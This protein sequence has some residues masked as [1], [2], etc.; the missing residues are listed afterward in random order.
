MFV[1]KLYLLHHFN[2][3]HL[4]KMVNVLVQNRRVR[5]GEMPHRL[6][7]YFFRVRHVELYNKVR[8]ALSIRYI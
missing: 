8:E 3:D 6:S 2:E 7:I 5:A 1:Q 4:R